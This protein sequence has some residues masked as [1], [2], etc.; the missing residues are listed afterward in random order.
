VR[1]LS[2]RSSS[3]ITKLSSRSTSANDGGVTVVVRVIVLVTVVVL[4][5]VAVAVVVLVI[6]VLGVVL[7]I[8][9]DVELVVLLNW[10]HS[11]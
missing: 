1:Y 5:D 7:V 4:L 2:T 9:V 10:G 8:G 6:E 3:N 11:T